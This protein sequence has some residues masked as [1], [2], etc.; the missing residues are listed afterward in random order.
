MPND[1]RTGSSAVMA[2][3]AKTG[4]KVKSFSGGVLYDLSGRAD[5]LSSAASG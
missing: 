2:A 4:K 5:A 1:G 3:V